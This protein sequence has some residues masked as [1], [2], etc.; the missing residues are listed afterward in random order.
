MKNR[1]IVLLSALVTQTILGG[2]YAWS[3]LTNYLTESYGISNAESGFI[4]GLSIAVFTVVMVFSGRLLSKKG[5][6]LPAL[7]ASVLYLVGYL[8]ASVAHGSYPL[9]LLGIGFIAGSGIGFGYVVPLSVGIQ[10]FPNHKGLVTGLSVGGFGGGA[11][12]LS[13]IIEAAI[14]S[15][16]SLDRY[17][18]IYGLVTGSLLFICSLLFTVPN[19]INTPINVAKSKVLKRYKILWLSIAGMF[20]GTFA[21]LLLVGNLAPF[22]R[23]Q[24]LS[25]LHA[26]FAVMLFSFGNL[27]GRIIWG[28]LFDR[29]GSRLIPQSL[30]LFALF[31]SL[32][33]VAGSELVLLVSILA[34]GFLFGSQFVLYAGLLSRTYCAAEFSKYYPLV[35]LSYGFAGIIA[36]GIGGWIVD[37]FGSYNAALYLCILLTLVG[38]LILLV[39][40]RSY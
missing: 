36:P 20:C 37:A 15:G 31:F 5:P 12:I 27:S 24:G 39:S 10:W 18:L 29:K 40:E 23:M 22:A 30:L 9:L 1:W 17:F 8:I 16:I 35:F 6:K 7:I 32:L 11:I 21:G 14:L 2:I 26:V 33:A 3:T 13:S 4:F 28:Y 25:E 38:A 34:L 19:Q